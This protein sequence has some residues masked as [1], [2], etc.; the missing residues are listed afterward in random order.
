MVEFCE[1]LRHVAL[2]DLARQALGDRRLADAGI[3]DE[4][5]VVL[6]A[7]AEHLDGALD[8]GL[9]ADQRID[10]ARPRLLVEVDAVGLERIGA[11]LLLLA[12]LDRRRAPRR[13]R[14]RARLGHAGPLGDAVA[15]VVDRVEA[16]HVLL[17]QEEGG[18]ALALGEDGDQHVG[19][20]HLLAAGGLHMRP[21]RDGSRAGSRRSAGR[22]RACRA[23]GPTSSLSRYSVSLSRS[24][25]RSTSQARITAAASRSSISDRSRC[26][27]VAYSW[28]RS[29]AYCRA[30]GE[31]LFETGRE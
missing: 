5:R 25:S 10:A 9:A 27:S 30:R 15:D 24:T 22:R 6:L 26:S 8:L 28:L 2:D 20:G 11:A 7:A 18:M 1:H 19:A 29:L 4:Q 16:G 31:S 17:L 12:A 13:R 21:R 14:A 23:P 3:A